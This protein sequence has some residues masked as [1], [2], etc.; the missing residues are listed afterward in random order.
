M[1]IWEGSI[2]KPFWRD[3]NSEADENGKLGPLKSLRETFFFFFFWLLNK[4]SGNIKG[5]LRMSLLFKIPSMIS[6]DCK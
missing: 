3:G 2:L 4:Y 1:Q 5:I 6:Q